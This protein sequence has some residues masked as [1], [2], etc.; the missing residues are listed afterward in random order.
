MVI[1]TTNNSTS[2]STTTQSIIADA[3]SSLSSGHVDPAAVLKRMEELKRC[4]EEE[5]IRLWRA[6]EAS[7]QQFKMQKVKFRIIDYF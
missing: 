7:M 1:T 2:T 3:P 4:Q 5:K 6:H